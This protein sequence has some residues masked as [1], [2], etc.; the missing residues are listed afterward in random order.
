VG[1]EVVAA[2]IGCDIPSLLDPYDAA[3]RSQVP[4]VF[5][6]LISMVVMTAVLV[7]EII[8]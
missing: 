1:G 6:G 3:T 2:G 4:S 5:L 8:I 7:R